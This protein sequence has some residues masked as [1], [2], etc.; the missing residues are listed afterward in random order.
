MLLRTRLP[1]HSTA[2]FLCTSTRRLPSL[3]SACSWQGTCRLPCTAGTSTE[4]IWTWWASTSPT[5]SLTVS[6]KWRAPH[7]TSYQTANHAT[8][9]FLWPST[10]MVRSFA[11]AASMVQQTGP[12]HQL[13]Y[14]IDIYNI[15]H[16]RPILLI[17]GNVLHLLVCTFT[18]FTLLSYFIIY[19]LIPDSYRC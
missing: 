4:W 16:V 18:V 15:E 8:E 1:H 17:F 2:Q 13:H 6:T 9:L 10:L 12:I 5:T 3:S 19:L 7:G 14:I 11:S